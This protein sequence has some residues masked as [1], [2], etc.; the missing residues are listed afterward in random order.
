M[1]K[2]LTMLLSVL[3]VGSFTACGGGRG[4][5]GGGG[6]DDNGRTRLT[7]GVY[8]GAVGYAWAEELEKEYEAL[9]TDVNIVINH[10]KGDYDDQSLSSRI[11]YNKEDMYFGSAN[12]L[13]AL[14]QK[15]HIIDLTDLV[16]EKCYDDA[17]NLVA[18]GGTKSIEDRMWDPWEAFNKVN[19][20]YYGVPNFAP[21]AGI[22]YDAD[23]FEEKGYEVPETYT[24]FKNLLDRMVADE[25][26]PMTI[27]DHEYI[28]F[29]AIAFWA[30]YEGVNNFM[31]NSTFEGTDSVLGA[32]TPETA[33]KL[34]GQQGRKAY[35]QYYKDL[36]SN[37]KYTT[38]QTRGGQSNTAS[39]NVF[40]SG[41]TGRGDRV[42]MITENSFWEREA[43]STFMSLG[44]IKEEYGW[45]KRNFKYMIAPVDNKLTDRHTVYLSYPNSHAFIS[46]YSDKKDLAKDFLKFTLSRSSLATYV[47]YTGVL[48]PY[49]FT[50]TAEEK[51]KATPFARS[52]MELL[53]RDDVDFAT[54]GAASKKGMQLGYASMYVQE[55]GSNSNIGG[56]ATTQSFP[57]RT[58]RANS[59]TTV[60][61]YF[62]GMRSY[63]K[64]KHPDMFVGVD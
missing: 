2:I 45:G 30:E 43:Y 11:P 16:Q 23:L 62:N 21:A 25:I 27:A 46:N 42:A 48:R 22:S 55:W 41:I 38:L 61:D 34:V 24:E 18:S 29:S 57:F 28:W 4:T 33:G 8:D 60:D 58:F 59:G 51:A 63:E 52:I 35:L 47:A 14:V 32:V 5:G 49:D 64:S 36:A 40:V 44:K 53:E 37:E 13:T 54:F 56:I 26:T 19:D 3:L 39:Q 20:R 9:H 17:G 1:K 50:V 31:L 7:V 12:S 6:D 10:K 15:G